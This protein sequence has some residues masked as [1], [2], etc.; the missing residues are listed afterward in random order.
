[1]STGRTGDID[2]RIYYGWRIVGV[3][4][5]ADFFAVGFLFYSF[6][7]FLKPLAAAFAGS[8]E[9][10]SLVLTA[11]FLSG[12]VAAPFL[13]RA[14]DR[15]RVRNIMIAGALCT[16]AGYA[17]TARAG[18]LGD[19]YWSFA[20][21]VGLGAAT[22]G[23]LSSATLVSNWFVARRGTALG[24]ATIGI[25]LSGFLMPTL[26]TALIEAVGWRE[27]YLVYA[28]LTLL[29]VVPPVA[30]VVVNRPEELG[31]HPD[32]AAHTAPGPDRRSEPERV[33]ATAEIL[34]DRQFWLI[35]ACF[36]CAFFATSGILVH[37]VPHATDLGIDDYRAAACL[38]V[39][40][41]F[42]TLAK[43]VFGYTVDRV[44]PRLALGLCF[45]TQ[46]LGV[47]AISRAGGEYGLLAGGAV[48][49]F[50][51]GGMVPLQGALTGD[52][53]G[54][55]SYGK[56]AGLMRPVQTPLHILGPP[57]AGRVF[58]ATHSYHLA[59]AL[60]AAAYCV[61]LVCIL[62]LRPR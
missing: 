33:W 51:F 6:S 31:L 34:R 49:G 17:L 38:S 18:S 62:G 57:L 47:A 52:L 12:S 20:V 41:G 61:S 23:G 21:L 53:F 30:F 43:F 16:S 10:V 2:H 3:A 24:I 48:F 5:L 29:V 28:A 22:M 58:D 56:V 35:S 46:L 11:S 55:L 42:A 45:G 1:M 14:L 36:G 4:F 37:L 32:G 13:G 59:F 7:V 8:R 54:R 15:F 25:S 60:F 19:L 26:A 40:A 50:G 27:A 9:A 44:S 39:A